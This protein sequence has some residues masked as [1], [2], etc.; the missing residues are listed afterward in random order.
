MPNNIPDYTELHA[1]HERRRE[2]ALR[3]YPICNHCDQRITEE[4]LYE[5]DG[6]LICEPCLLE[7]FR[8]KTSDFM[9][10]E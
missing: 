8:K 6:V 7:D 4:Y 10:E 5:I 2:R 3:K 9:E 1:M